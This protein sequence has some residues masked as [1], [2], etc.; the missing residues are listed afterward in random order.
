MTASAAAVRG[1]VLGARVAIAI[2]CG[3]WLWAIHP[4]P[5]L[6]AA[7]LAMLGLGAAGWVWGMSR[8]P[9]VSPMGKSNGGGGRRSR[10]VGF[11]LLV[12][13]E[14]AG[15]NL[16]A[17]LLGPEALRIY[18]IPAISF[19]VGLH[20][21]PMLWLFRRRELPVC[22]AAMIAA[23]AGAVLAIRQ[24]APPA[25]VVGVEG[26]VNA[27][28]LWATAGYSLSRLRRALA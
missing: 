5:L 19:V 13:A 2:G 1:R 8:M 7:Q 11:S 20:F 28:I 15:L 9:N 6:A 26:G 12:V 16:V 24:G 10:A 4:L 23:S 18:L 22:G 21:I 27:I 14:I 17:W 25:L 3:W